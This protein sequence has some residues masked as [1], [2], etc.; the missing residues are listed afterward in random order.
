MVNSHQYKCAHDKVY[1]KIPDYEKYYRTFVKMGVV[2][3]ITTVKAKV[4]D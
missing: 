2:L 4:E 3:S 1:G